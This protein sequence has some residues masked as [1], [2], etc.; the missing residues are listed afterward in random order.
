MMIIEK[1][2]SFDAGESFTLRNIKAEEVSID[3]IEWLNSAEV[4][5]YLSISIPI[6]LEEQISYISDKRES[7]TD[8]YVGLFNSE[9]KLIGTSGIQNLSGSYT[10]SFGIVIGSPNY[11]GI[12]LGKYLIYFISKMIF[13][14]SD[15]NKIYIEVERENVPSLSSFLWCGYKFVDDIVIHVTF[16]PRH[17]IKES[18]RY[19]IC[20]E[21]DLKLQSL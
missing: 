11:R 2:C 4:N 18:C 8:A 10:C 5:K 16:D 7:E 14:Q 21:T 3:Y 17:K 19:M 13:E 20:E 1:S 6:T 15:N 9:N 12:G